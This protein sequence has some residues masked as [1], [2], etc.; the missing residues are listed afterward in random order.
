[1]RANEIMIKYFL[2]LFLI[3]L[4]N[5]LFCQNKSFKKDSINQYNKDSLKEGFWIEEGMHAEEGEPT[6]K[7]ICKGKYQNGLKENCWK[8]FVKDSDILL[9]EIY[10]EKGV[11]T[12]YYKSYYYDTGTLHWDQDYDKGIAIDYERNGEIIG[13]QERLKN[14][15]SKHENYSSGKVYEIEFY[16]KNHEKE[17]KYL[18]YLHGNLAE[19]ATYANGLLNG[20]DSLFYSNGQIQSVCKYANQKREGV[21][22]E[23]YPSGKIKYEI[24]YIDG[25]KDGQ[26]FYYG[27]DGI[28]IE[29]SYY[30]KGVKQTP[31]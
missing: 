27:E 18:R 11:N 12:H 24:T 28:V 13:K 5:T 22:K 25:I 20:V 16:N 8:C 6:V 7:I 1:M 3:L 2:I 23:Y 30:M 31:K 19:S 15:I 29:S 4:S 26:Y 10:Y 14:G 17:G 9:S 21:Y